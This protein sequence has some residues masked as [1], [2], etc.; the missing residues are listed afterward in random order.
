LKVLDPTQEQ[1]IDSTSAY[2]NHLGSTLKPVAAN[3]LTCVDGWA[4]CGGLSLGF[5]AAG[6]D[7][8]GF[9]RNPAAVKTYNTNLR[10]KCSLVNIDCDTMFPECD[11]F[12]AGPP[13][14]PFS[15]VGEQRGKDD[16]R[17]GFPAFVSAIRRLRPKAWLF[18]NVP[19]ILGRHQEYIGDLIGQLKKLDYFV[20]PFVVNAADCGVPQNRRRLVVIGSKHAIPTPTPPGLSVTAGVALGGLARRRLGRDLY[21]T[22]NQES[23]IANYEKKSKCQPRD[24]HLDRPAR[25][26]TCRNLGGATSDMQRLRFEDGSRRRLSIGE[27]ARLQSFP[28]GFTFHGGRISQM[29]QIGNAVP[30]LLARWLAD[31]LVDAI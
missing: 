13:C 8:Q 6:F 4:G 23:Y 19:N 3:G 7:V 21:L 15:V 5:E 18:E 26:L 17:N 30:P 16:E 28:P 20:T 24:L 14:Q 10:G 2:L 29:S 27:A 22:Q 31:T 1:S 9:E 25:T 12:I 11:I